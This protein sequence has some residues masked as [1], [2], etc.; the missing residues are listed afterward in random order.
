MSEHPSETTSPVKAALA[1]RCPRCARGRLFKGYLTVAPGCDVC[2]LDFAGHDSADGPAVLIILFL[3]FI[4]AG[5]A[6]WLEF[7]VAPPTWVHM[8]IWPPVIL[9]LALGALRPLKA[10]F[11]GLQYKYRSVERE[12]PDE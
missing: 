7:T 10:A 9:V 5:G 1:G 8:V 2:G 3:G 4:I 11:I 6:F 12:F